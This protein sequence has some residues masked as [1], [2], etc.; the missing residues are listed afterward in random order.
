VSAIAAPK[1]LPSAY[2]GAG[3]ANLRHQ[4]ELVLAALAA[5]APDEVEPA[6]E[7]AATSEDEQQQPLMH[8]ELPALISVSKAAKVLAISRASAYRYAACEDLPTVR[9]GGRLYIVT[10][11]LRE[12]LEAA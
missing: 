5:A 2:D 10:A 8:D 11:R 9:L 4:L 6:R 3:N 7:T 1:D 12:F